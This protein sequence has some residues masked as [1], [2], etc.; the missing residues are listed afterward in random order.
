MF[1]WIKTHSTHWER[2]TC[3]FK[4]KKKKWF[5]KYIY[6]FYQKNPLFKTS[7]KCSQWVRRSLNCDVTH[8]DVL[9]RSC[10]THCMVLNWGRIKASLELQST[11]YIKS[12]HQQVR[13][14]FFIWLFEDTI[15][16][17]GLAIGEK[18]VT[19]SQI[20]WFLALFWWS[21]FL[22]LG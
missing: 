21:C 9:C 16:F 4:K 7:Q 19:K 13:F 15:T 11:F 6:I 20:S 3:H 14:L 18:L 5:V 12:M 10:G 2:P 17:E 8:D 1:L 22:K